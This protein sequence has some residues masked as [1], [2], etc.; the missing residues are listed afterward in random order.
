MKFDVA[1]I[2]GGLAGLSAAARLGAVGARVL[3]AEARPGL[4]GRASSF[5]D[6]ATGEPVDNGQHLML[7]CYH[8]TFAFLG[9][10]GASAN[11]RVQPGLEVPFVDPAGY[12][13]VLSC[14]PLPSP[15]QLLAGL[16]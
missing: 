1:V 5:A 3:L 4:G 10:I 6:P 12:Q 16:V 2:G 15:F 14:P 13:S 11:V 8:E 7:G 9:R